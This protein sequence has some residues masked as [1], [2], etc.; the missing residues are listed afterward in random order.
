MMIPSLARGC[1]KKWGGLK[2]R[3]VGEE[4]KKLEQKKEAN[5]E[6]DASFFGDWEKFVFQINKLFWR[7]N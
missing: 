4:Q 6:E 3:Y 1:Q 5:Q 2:E 7:N